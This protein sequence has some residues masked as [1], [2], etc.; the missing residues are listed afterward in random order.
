MAAGMVMLPVLSRRLWTDM[1][2]AVELERPARISCS[3]GRLSA[4]WFVFGCFSGAF[5]SGWLDIDVWVCVCVFCAYGVMEEGVC[6][7]IIRRK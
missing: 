2:L 6:G 3:V 7:Q 4:I 5:T 1:S